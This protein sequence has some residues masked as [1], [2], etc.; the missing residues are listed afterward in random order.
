MGCVF[1]SFGSHSSCI[2]GRAVV[3]VRSVS[4]VLVATGNA[5]R[6]VI[7]VVVAR[8]DRSRESGSAVEAGIARGAD[9]A[10]GDALGLVRVIV[11][12]H[13]ETEE[14]AVV[15]VALVLDLVLLT[16]VTDAH[17]SGDHHRQ[18]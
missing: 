17:Q 6:V 9:R 16:I 3:I 2:L 14:I 12:V 1:V 10:R 4:A 18:G 7:V 11:V 5:A 13:Q 8:A 15:I